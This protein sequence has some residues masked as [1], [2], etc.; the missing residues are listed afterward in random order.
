M[1]LKSATF[2]ALKRSSSSTASLVK[3]LGR[4]GEEGRGRKRE[5]EGG[6]RKGVEE[7]GRKKRKRGERK[8]KKGEEEVM[9]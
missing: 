5:E 8:G 7:E 1:L 2:C 9:M 4:E 6:E 3:I